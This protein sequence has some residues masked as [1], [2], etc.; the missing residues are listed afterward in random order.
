MQ[1]KRKK[2]SLNERIKFYSSK[3]NKS[4]D[5]SVR[6]T[7]VGY[8][9]GATGDVIDSSIFSTEKEKNAYYKGVDRGNKAKSASANAKF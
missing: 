8:L 5:K 4:N 9:D 1:K 2:F 7:C 3:L 6:A